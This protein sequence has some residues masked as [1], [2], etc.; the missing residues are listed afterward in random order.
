MP[1]DQLLPAHDDSL[2]LRALDIFR[3]RKILAVTVFGVVL[4]SAVSFAIYLPDL[5]R[6]TTVVLVERPVPEAFV[7]PAVSGELEGRLHV[8]R[9][10]ILSRARLTELIERFNL[11]PELRQH[12]PLETALDQMRNDMQIELTGPEHV[13]GRK[14]TVAF[15]LSYTG[16]SGDTVA[17]VTNALAAFY[18]AQ[19]YD[20]RSGEATRTTGFLKAQLDGA[21]RELEQR[22]AGLRAYTT[23]HPG[24]LPQQV[25][26]NLAAL[27]RLNTQLRLN[28][29]RQLRVLEESEK[30]SEG[31]AAAAA[32]AAADGGTPERGGPVGVNPL[33][34]RLERMKRE[35]QLLEAQ[36]FT[37]R[38]PDVVRLKTEI[39]SLERERQDSLV[40]EAERAKAEQATRE[41]AAPP[42]PSPAA[43]A[44][45]AATRRRTLDGMTAELEKL[46]R[47]EA[48]LRQTIA[49]FEKR[50]EAVPEREQE[51]GRLTRDYQAARDVY[52]SLLKR[53]DEAQLGETMEVD[54]QGE[55]FRILE[56]A[57]PPPSP[58][59]PNR[60]RLLIVGLL[61]AVATGVAAVLAV[62]R[63]D[64]TFHSIDDIRAFTRV[65]VMATI[66][67]IK[68]AFWK[69]A[70][71]TAVAAACIVAV[72]ALSA[73]MSAR[74]ARGNQQVVWMLT[75][76]A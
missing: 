16:A 2:V 56:P 7:R 57:L 24:E 75:R 74:L 17:D 29:E 20:I 45:A 27:E 33:A 32:A 14:T 3:R 71:R 36:R 63:F 15:K 58:S 76:G 42:P 60:L 10:E 12:S 39:A 72:I 11:Y 13:S 18:V 69:R 59:A 8:I 38:H 68:S 47:E 34:E 40:R 35:L 70:L 5:Y 28:G 51:F 43:V 64:E 52:D 48:G 73:V 23:S 4:A 9:Q 19:N 1:R 31:M 37:S 21:R 67:D 65:P 44:T 6:A 22:E 49:E 25:E 62:E 41:A 61:L 54:R 55:R 46:K 26:V 50:L 66:P 30:L 53:F